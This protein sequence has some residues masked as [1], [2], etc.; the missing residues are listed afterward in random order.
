METIDEKEEQEEERKEEEEKDEKIV[1][2]NGTSN[3]YQINKLKKEKVEEKIRKSISKFTETFG[4]E[5]IPPLDNQISLL[6]KKE[7]NKKEREILFSHLNSKISSYKQQDIDKQIYFPDSFISF[8]FL[9]ETLLESELKCHYCSHSLYLLYA[10]VREK[11]QWTLDRIDNSL[12]HNIDNVVIS[13]LECN[14]ARR[15]INK[16]AFLFT[17]QLNLV[18]MA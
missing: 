18:K 7:N 9:L 8:D 2:I 6:Y 4:Q 11:K 5:L 13:C 12:G 17:K 3:R 14:L 1:K 15:N 16:K 10:K